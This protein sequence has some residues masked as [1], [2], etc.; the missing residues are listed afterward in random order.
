MPKSSARL[1]STDREIQTIKVDSLRAEFRI[2]GA[3]NLVLR[4]T[5]GG[6]KTWTFLYRSPVS[7][8]R[9]KLSIGE[10]PSRSLA[11]ARTEALVLTLA[12]DQGKDP[13]AERRAD[14]GC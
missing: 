10:Y 5:S 13:L 2:K 8:K 1:L 11:S 9:A 3:R 4:V 7:G 14:H 6:T 12:V